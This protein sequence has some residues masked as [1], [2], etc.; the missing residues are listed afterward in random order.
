MPASTCRRT[1]RLIAGSSSAPSFLNGVMSAVPTPVNWVRMEGDLN[2]SECGI[3]NA[4]SGVQT[5]RVA[6]VTRESGVVCI[7]NSE[8]CIVLQNILHRVPPLP[9]LNPLGGEQRAGG[10]A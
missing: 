2:N 3:Q 4:E 1:S 9:P 10:E 7:L 8:F 5:S 6:A